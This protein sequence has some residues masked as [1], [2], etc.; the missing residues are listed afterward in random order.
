MNSPI[1]LRLQTTPLPEPPPAADRGA[2]FTALIWIEEFVA[3][4]QRALAAED[5]EQERRLCEDELL[6]RVPYLRAAGVFDVF[7]VR[8]PALRAMIEDCALPELRSV[9]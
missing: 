9:A 5:D 1:P 7:E 2:A 8:H 4:A 6:R 3:L